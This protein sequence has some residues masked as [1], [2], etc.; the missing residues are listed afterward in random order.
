MRYRPPEGL[1]TD[2]LPAPGEPTKRKMD[3]NANAVPKR[4]PLTL[5]AACKTCA[6]DGELVR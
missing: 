6:G 1:N 2:T 3:E 5:P 4:S